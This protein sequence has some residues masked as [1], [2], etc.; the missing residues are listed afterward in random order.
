MIE[1]DYHFTLFL[2]SLPSAYVSREEKT[3]IKYSSGV[4]VG[5]VDKNNGE[6][7]LY[8]HL[9]IIITVSETIEDNNAFRIIGF[10]IEPIS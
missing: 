2:D 1:R 7:Y 3:L 4:P 8:N 6:V 5:F 9:E 10:K